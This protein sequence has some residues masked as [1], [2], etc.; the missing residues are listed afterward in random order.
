[1]GMLLMANGN[2]I[3]TKLVWWILGILAL[4][5]G[6]VT[7]LL[8]ND[9]NQYVRE[10]RGIVNI[11]GTVLTTLSGKIGANETIISSLQ[12]DIVEMKSDIGRLRDQATELKWQLFIL[13][14]KP[15]SDGKE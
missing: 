14:P 2:S 6:A 11:Q 4:V 8:W 12:K 10:T 9:L 13:V 15:K 5:C 3:G 1:M 7:M